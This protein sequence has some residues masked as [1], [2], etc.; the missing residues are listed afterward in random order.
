[1][2]PTAGVHQTGDFLGGL[3]LGFIRVWLAFRHGYLMLLQSGSPFFIA[4]VAAFA[5]NSSES[6]WP[7]IHSNESRARTLASTSLL[8]PA[9]C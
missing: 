4:F 7:P 9:C 1:M 2:L 3:L 6:N 8:R 5:S